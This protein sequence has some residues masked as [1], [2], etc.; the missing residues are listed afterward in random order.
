MSTTR[1]FW[2]L[3]SINTSNRSVS[4]V[5]CN[6]YRVL[7]VL[8]VPQC[9]APIA[10]DAEL[11]QSTC[12]NI[13]IVWALDHIEEFFDRHVMLPTNFTHT[14]AAVSVPHD[15]WHLISGHI[16]DHI[17]LAAFETVCKGAAHSADWKRLVLSCWR[18]ED[19][20]AHQA[21]MSAPHPNWK[22]IFRAIYTEHVSRMMYA[23][24]HCGGNHYVL[25]TEE[26]DKFYAQRDIDAGTEAYGGNCICIHCTAGSWGSC[27]YANGPSGEIFNAAEVT[28]PSRCLVQ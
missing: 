11:Q 17:T 5:E 21:A 6:L 14:I 15:V 24:P 22:M 1:R 23:C 20:E 9:K 10:S 2:T 12:N 19:L 26:W 7:T 8:S 13:A 3:S 18:D 28:Q 25:N 27:A 4:R 16:D